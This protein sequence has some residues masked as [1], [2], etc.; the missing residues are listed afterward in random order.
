MKKTDLLLNLYSEMFRIRACE[1][2]LVDP[3]LSG[4][5]KTPCHLCSGQEAIAVGVCSA[6]KKS[7][8]ILA[9]TVRMGIIWLKGEI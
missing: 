7:D 1:E 3:I 5:I 9:G 6:L 4:E 2:S 8:A